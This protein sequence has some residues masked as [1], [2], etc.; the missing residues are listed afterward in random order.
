MGFATRIRCTLE[1]VLFA[2][3]PSAA[4][5]QPAPGATVKAEE[6]RRCAPRALADGVGRL[7]EPDG[8]LS[9]LFP[10]CLAIG[11]PFVLFRLKRQGFSGCSVRAAREGLYVQGRR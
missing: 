11:A 1:L 6:V 2:L 9:I 3:L 5:G 4:G 8:T 10:G 7:L